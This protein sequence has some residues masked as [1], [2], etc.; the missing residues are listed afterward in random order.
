MD[1]ITDRPG[2]PL[3]DY[4][5]YKG[6]VWAASMSPHDRCPTLFALHECPQLEYSL[7][8]V[9]GLRRPRYRQPVI[10]VVRCGLVL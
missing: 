2:N 3:S 8:L 10:T 1:T 5:S 6:R 9:H 7:D 4:C